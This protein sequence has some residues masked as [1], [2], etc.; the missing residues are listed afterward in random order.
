MNISIVVAMSKNR[1]IGVKNTLPWHLP[2]DLAHFK[3]MTLGKPI[4]MGRKTF[5]AIGRPLPDRDNIILTRDRNFK[6]PGCEVVHELDSLLA[7]Q[8]IPELMVIGGANIYAQ[9]L[10]FT[11]TLYITYVDVELSG[12]AFFPEIARKEWVQTQCE[13]R[14]KDEKNA[15]HCTFVT[16]ERINQ[17]GIITAKEMSSL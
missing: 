15:Y 11:T 5:E 9:L 3:K 1:V 7:R 8:D 16:L 13:E 6:A 17:N 14:V 12:D 10:P 2:A 4:V